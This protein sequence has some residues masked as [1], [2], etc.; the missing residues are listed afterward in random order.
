MQRDLSAAPGTERANDG[1]VGDDP[2][3]PEDLAAI[4]AQCREFAGQPDHAHLQ[5]KA[6]SIALAGG[7]TAV[8]VA[9]WLGLADAAVTPFGGAPP[10]EQ[11]GSPLPGGAPGPPLPLVALPPPALSRPPPRRV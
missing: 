6:R 3:R 7:L 8:V 9:A 1:A 10:P 4:A 11:G 2:G 5:M